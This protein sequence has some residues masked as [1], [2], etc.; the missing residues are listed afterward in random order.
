MDI[1]CYVT[2]FG[3]FSLGGWVYECTFCAIKNRRWDNRG[4]LFGPVC[5]IYGFAGVAVLLLLTWLPRVL[6]VSSTSMPWWEVFVFCSVGSAVLEY[7]TSYLLERFFHARWW[8]YSKIPLNLNGRICLPFALCFGLAGTLGYYYLA[9]PIASVSSGV[10]LV[11]W[12]VLALFIVGLMCADLGLTVSALTDLGKRIE[13]AQ[14][15]FD[16]VMN[17]AVTDIASGRPPLGEDV[18]QSTK[19]IAA[20]MSGLQRRALRTV[21]NFTSERRNAAAQRL[22]RALGMAEREA[23]KA[24]ERLERDAQEAGERVE[25]GLHEAEGRIEREAGERD[26]RSDRREHR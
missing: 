20:G 9:I 25:H 8:D 1:C 10:P 22:R 5:P 24:G 19:R 3:V 12:E 7:L 11:T 18:S 21:T 2:W 17:V 26:D 14:S 4:F 16:A 15:A 13:S 23:H 6:S